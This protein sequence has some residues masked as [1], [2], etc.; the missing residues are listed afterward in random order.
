MDNLIRGEYLPSLADKVLAHY[1]KLYCDPNSIKNGDTIYCDTHHIDKFLDIL[2]NKRNLKIITH[3]SDYCLYD[4]NVTYNGVNVENYKGCYRVWLGQNSYSEYVT[5][6]PIGFE[7]RRWEKSFGPKTNWTEE[8]KDETI[9]PSNSVYLNCN[10]DT[11]LKDR[12][13]CYE[14]VSGFS[15]VTCDK[16]NLAYKDYLRKIKSHK[17]TLSP[18]GNGLDCHRTWET[19]MMN[20]IP[21][22][23]KEGS[24]EKLYKGLPVLFV[25]DWD[26]IASIDLDK[27]YEKLKFNNSEFLTLK[28]WTSNENKL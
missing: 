5:P 3:N 10:V 11:N 9:A 21:I 16:P 26:Q 4:K 20:R 14:K 28:Y 15:F 1:D 8:V 22:I 25:D 18:R 17:F 7:N 13:E 27:Q 2:I 23:K 6:L 19:L 12:K 24:L